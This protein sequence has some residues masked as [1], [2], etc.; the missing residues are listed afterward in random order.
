MNNVRREFIQ[1]LVDKLYDIQSDLDSIQEEE[2]E[3]F[4]N[5]PENLQNSERYEQAGAAVAALDSAA[6]NLCECINSLE[7]A[8]G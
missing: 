7:E 8:M 4:D 1:N 5:I 6:E 3:A 2:Q